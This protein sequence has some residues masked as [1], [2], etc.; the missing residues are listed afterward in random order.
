MLRFYKKAVLIFSALLIISGIL[1]YICIQNTFLNIPLLPHQDTQIKWRPEIDSDQYSGGQST[2]RLNDTEYMLDMDAFVSSAIEHPY[3]ALALR[4]IDSDGQAKLID[5]SKYSTVSFNVKCS[6]ENTLTF[7]VFTYDEKLSKKDDFL[8]YRAPSMFFT[9]NPQW[10]R[11]Q[12]DLSRLELQLWWFYMFQVNLSHNDYFLDKVAKI[13]FSTTGQSP[14][15][16][17]TRIQINQLELRARDWS[18]LTIL[19][20]VLGLIW[21]CAVIIFFRYHKRALTAELE[22]KLIKER[23]LI[24]YQQL[25]LQAN[26]DKSKEALLKFLA[27]E[28]ANPELNLEITASSVG[29]SRT[30]VNEILKLELGFTFTGYLNKLRLTEAARL[31][32]ESKDANIAEVAYSVGYKNVSYFNK[33]FKAEFSCTPKAYQQVV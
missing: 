2:N 9:C 4:F 16:V 30:K 22:Q 13:Q 15:D 21:T 33:L 12:V 20:I 1:S 19:A 11:I 26:R 25:S 7:I 10:Q 32:S 17:T 3:S 28:Y 29:I 31:L 27:T 8:T 6:I 18:V 5:L 14:T 23:P 24:A